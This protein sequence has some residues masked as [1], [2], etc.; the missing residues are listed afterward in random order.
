MAHGAAWVTYYLVVYSYY[1]IQDHASNH[2][3]STTPAPSTTTTTAT[4]TASQASSLDHPSSTALPSLQPSSRH[5]PAQQ[6]LGAGLGALMHRYAWL[7][8][9]CVSYSFLRRHTNPLASEEVS[10]S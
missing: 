5:A 10:L 2:Q 7:L 8:V 4:T 9:A 6:P 1:Q 3:L